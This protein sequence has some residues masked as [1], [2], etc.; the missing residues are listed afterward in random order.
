[1]ESESEPESESISSPESEPESESEQPHYDSTPLP[2]TKEPVN[3]RFL[4]PGFLESNP[5]FGFTRYS[6]AIIG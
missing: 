6:R 5:C 2:V 1:M 3:F 4:I